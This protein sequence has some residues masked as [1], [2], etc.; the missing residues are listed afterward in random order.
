IRTTTA[1]I[2][3]NLIF[4]VNPRWT[5]ASLWLSLL[6]KCSPQR[7]REPQRSHRE[8][9]FGLKFKITSPFLPRE[10][11]GWRRDL[12]RKQEFPLRPERLF[13]GIQELQKRSG[14]SP[15]FLLRRPAKSFTVARPRGI[16]TRFPILP[17]FMRGT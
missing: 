9:S 1:T 5:S 16:F 8:M 17:A 10:A 3:A 11:T 15:G 2:R 7:H 12:F 4:S 14:R 13:A 6:E